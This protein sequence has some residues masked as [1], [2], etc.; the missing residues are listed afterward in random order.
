MDLHHKGMERERRP[1]GEPNSVET[2]V[3]R[4]CSKIMDRR[5]NKANGR[6]KASGGGVYLELFHTDWI[7]FLKLPF[8]H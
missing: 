1:E 4:R 7:S 3:T 8:C 2:G 5:V 6:R